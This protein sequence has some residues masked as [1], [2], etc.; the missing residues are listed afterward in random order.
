MLLLLVFLMVLPL[1]LLWKHRVN[2][3][4]L[5]PPGPPGLPLIG[6][7]HQLER[8]ATHRYLWH[9]SKQ[10]GPLMFLRLGFE[11]ILVVSSPRTAEVMKTHDPEF[12]SRPS[13]LALQKLSYNGLDLAFA[14]YGTDTVTATMVWTMTALMKNPRVMKKAQKEV[15]TLVGEKCFVD[16]DDIQKLTYMKALV[17]EIMRLYPAA[18]L[19]IPRE[20]LQKCNIDGYEIPSKTLVF[21]NAWAI[22]RDPESWENPE[23]FMPERFLGTCI[24]FKGQDYKLIPF[25]AGRRIWPGMNLGAVTV[26]LALANLL[27]SF[28]W[29]MPAGMKMEDIDTDAKPGLTMT[30]KN[31][32]YL[33]ARNYI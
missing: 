20:T 2:G 17:K 30:K 22:G 6:N 10:Y 5:L 24:D 13:L 16:E 26:E 27:Y 18:P 11:P 21:V 19:L 33:V 25:G 29:E 3:G 9:L 31:D 1:F 4:K 12:S 7:L 32:L 14:S 15:R 23:E 28:D 8:S